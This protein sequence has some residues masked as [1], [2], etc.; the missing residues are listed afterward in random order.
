MANGKGKGG[1]E[2]ENEEYVEELCFTSTPTHTGGGE[3]ENEEYVEELC[4]T[5]TPTHTYVYPHTQTQRHTHA[6]THARTHAHAHAYEHTHP[7]LL[8]F[9]CI[10]KRC[11]HG[12]LTWHSSKESMVSTT[13]MTDA[14]AVPSTPSSLSNSMHPFGLGETTMRA[15][16]E[17]LNCKGL[18]SMIEPKPATVFRS[19]LAVPLPIIISSP[20]LNPLV[21]TVSR[22]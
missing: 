2:T 16:E 5:S 21:L 6:R 10:S 18:A 11:V 22:T 15:A 20:T 3:T 4:F 19:C 14:I 12:A 7:T 17:W 1:G 8:L 9:W 13:L